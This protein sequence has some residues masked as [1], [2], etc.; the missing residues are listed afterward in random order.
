MLLGF[1]WQIENYFLSKINPRA[2]HEG[3]GVTPAAHQTHAWAGSGDSPVPWI[4][5]PG[6]RGLGGW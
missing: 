4:R 5:Y 2:T 6:G 1:V 3:V